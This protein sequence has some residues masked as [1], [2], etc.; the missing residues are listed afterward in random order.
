MVQ[1]LKKTYQ[2]GR[3]ASKLDPQKQKEIRENILERTQVNSDENIEKLKI[4][5]SLLTEKRK[6][7][8]EVAER[9]SLGRPIEAHRQNKTMGVVFLLLFFGFLAS[10]FFLLQWT[11]RPFGLGTESFI[12]SFGL[13]LAGVTAIEEYLRSLHSRNPSIYSKWVLWLVFFSVICFIVS[14]TD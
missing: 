4:Q 14:W 2:E 13:M 11:F 8:A 12:I 3:K 6:H 7:L 1:T 9:L 10:E 5:G